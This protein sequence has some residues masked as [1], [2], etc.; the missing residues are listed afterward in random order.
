LEIQTTFLT[1]VNFVKYKAPIQTQIM[2][3]MPKD[4]LAPA[5]AWSA[6]VLCGLIVAAPVWMG[7]PD[8]AHDSYWHL[9]WS[10][11]FLQQFW[12]GDLYPRWLENMNGGL[13]SPAFFFYPPLPYFAA[14]PFFPLT[15]ITGNPWYALAAGATLA[16]VASGLA[17]YRWLSSF[18]SSQ[19][20][21]VGAI[22]YMA[23]PYHLGVDLY[24]RFAYAELWGFVWMPLVLYAS[25]PQTS[26]QSS[27]ATAMTVVAIAISFALLCLS[28]LPT[29][30]LF[31]AL[32][33]FQAVV[34][35]RE[36]LRLKAGASVVA[37][38]LLG[39]GVAA[40]Y[41][42]P[43]W[44][45]RDLTSMLGVATGT[46]H[47]ANNFL[48]HN[49]VGHERAFWRLLETATLFAVAFGIY[50]AAI[51][52]QRG[53]RLDLLTSYWLTI[54]VASAIMTTPISTPIW[55]A[56]PPFQNVQFPWRF[57]SI[58][59]L[60]V[61]A[62]VALSVAQ[63]QSFKPNEMD[64]NGW[65]LA[66]F[67]IA[68]SVAFSFLVLLALV[69]QQWRSWH[70]LWLSLA[71]A[72]GALA[73]CAQ[74]V[75]YQRKHREIDRWITGFAVM[76]LILLL[77]NLGPARTE[78]RFMNLHGN[79]ASSR[80]AAPE[81]VAMVDLRDYRIS[82]VPESTFNTD[83]MTALALPENFLRVTSGDGRAQVITRSPRAIAISVVADT[84]VSATLGRYYYPGTAL[85]DSNGHAI[86][87]IGP[88]PDTGLI[89]AELPA[90]SYTAVVVLR[91]GD[92]E[93][94]GGWISLAAAMVAVLLG[95]Y[96]LG[97][98]KAAAAP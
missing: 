33:V 43:A 32:P 61:A 71:M 23:V 63:L 11:N 50:V 86:G 80:A 27:S 30:V 97:S 83:T 54:L 67:R 84:P 51:S 45:D 3:T 16:S 46:Y 10:Q 88:T 58:S 5:V 76:S 62:L 91:P 39:I 49:P 19:A 74:V 73:V 31:A 29:V 20:A 35:S 7:G 6:I 2:S 8:I 93:R 78:L 53:K 95:L 9:H 64:S 85:E 90:G 4:R 47:Y 37:G 68:P 18:T 70:S 24:I 60:A 38:M 59:S 66:R 56:F 55:K 26:P 89:H 36:G 28:H 41:L 92:M 12:R 69:A 21:V 52:W 96:G 75:L 48:F 42:L 34:L 40:I 25:R 82:H 81:N 72:F 15:A 65:V 22:L 44:G 87:R 98:R 13:G 79:E 94:L 57:G 17:A 1:L 14:T 77:P